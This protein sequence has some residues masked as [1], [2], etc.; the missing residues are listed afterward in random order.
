MNTQNTSEMTQN[1]TSVKHANDYAFVESSAIIKFTYYAN[2]FHY[3][4]I[5]RVWGEERIYNDGKT[6][7][8]TSLSNHLQTKW[9]VL[10]TKLSCARAETDNRFVKNL[11]GTELFY[12]FYMMLDNSNKEILNNFILNSKI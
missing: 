11:T 1:Q 3:D 2:N 10:V 9:D 8:H 7:I 6:F 5:Q 12:K 4:F